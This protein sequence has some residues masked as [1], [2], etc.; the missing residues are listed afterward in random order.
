MKYPLVIFD[1]DGTILDTLED[2]K[3]SLNA[4]LSACGY[5]ER[6]LS[7]VRSFVGNGLY[8]LMVL[9]TPPETSE[10]EIQRVLA[11]FNA[12][13][14]IHCADHT[15]PY[16]GIL[17]LICDLRKKGHKTAVVSNKADYAVQDLCKQY[18]DGLFDFAVGERTGVRKKPAPDSVNE[19]LH[20]L[21]FPR[22]E[23]VY[24]GDSE[25]DIETAK[26]A[27][28]PCIVVTWGFRDESFL[29]ERGAEILVSA[30]EEILE[31]I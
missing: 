25:V 31:I 3:I 13:Y 6:T 14:K 11:A 28:L 9:S 27:G 29:R 30:P 17:E 4:A 19:V 24:V 21:N 2:L 5:P 1:L 12:H 16:R 22:A 15:R 26:N 18:F 8:R 10:E 20:T 23:A 7:E